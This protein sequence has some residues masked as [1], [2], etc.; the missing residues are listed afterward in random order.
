MVWRT[1][2]LAVVISW[3]YLSA[4]HESIPEMIEGLGIRRREFSR[5]V[6]TLVLRGYV[7]REIDPRY[8]TVSL[9]PTERGHAANEATFEGCDYVDKEARAQAVRGRDG[10]PAPWT[11]R[12]RRDQAVI[13][14]P[15]APSWPA[16]VRSPISILKEDAPAARPAVPALSGRDGSA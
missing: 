8:G 11:R 5:L 3:G 7:T 13:D 6:D 9:V 2:P 1:F 12:A 4:A 15:R 10:R 16:A 14:G